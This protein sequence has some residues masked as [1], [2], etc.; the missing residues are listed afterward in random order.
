MSHRPVLR[1]TSGFT[2]APAQRAKGGANQA[3]GYVLIQGVLQYPNLNTNAETFS[4]VL[5]Y[6]ATA[7]LDF[8]DAI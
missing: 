4:D 8:P 1:A 6:K 2:I 3:P 5:V 7:L